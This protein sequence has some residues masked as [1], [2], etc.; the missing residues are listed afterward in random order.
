ML[1]GGKKAAGILIEAGTKPITQY[2]VLSTQYFVVGIGLNVNLSP[3]DFEA[4]NLPDA[5]SLSIVTGRKLDVKAITQA[6]IHNL[7]ELYSSL[8]AGAIP[9]LEECWARRLG[10]V[11]RHA[12]VELMDAT[13]L[14]GRVRRIAFDAVELEQSNGDI[15]VLRPEEIRH[16]R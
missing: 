2:S 7:D 9:A 6:L 4:M 3:E 14:H 12:T 10:K 15:R 16:I 13:E 8:L 11:D 1:V 5:T